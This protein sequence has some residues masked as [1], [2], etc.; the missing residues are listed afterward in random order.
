[1]EWWYFFYETPGHK[2]A[3]KVDLY[4]VC[5][6]DRFLPLLAAASDPPQAA[7]ALHNTHTKKILNSSRV[8]SAARRDLVIQ[9]TNN[10]F[11]SLF[12]LQTNSDTCFGIY[13]FIVTWFYLF[14]C[15]SP[16]ALLS[17]KPVITYC[18]NRETRRNAW[19][20][21]YYMFWTLDNSA[22]HL[23]IIW[24]TFFRL[25]YF[26]TFAFHSSSFTTE[27][28]PLNHMTGHIRSAHFKTLLF[29][30][31]PGQTHQGRTQ[32]QPEKD[33][34]GPSLLLYR[35]MGH[36][37]Y[38]HSPPVHVSKIF[39]IGPLLMLFSCSYHSLFSCS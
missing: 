39:F 28:Q 7:L 12:L 1:M 31:D 8:N 35:D 32:S 16:G 4:E 17:T 11:A 13:L 9:Y 14:W 38:F 18:Y 29:P 3:N 20:C 5:I 6:G 25:A 26:V 24:I 21:M 34:N 19:Q 33:P 30:T 23:S 37:T 22:K 10:L 36:F 27:G 15:R 2:P